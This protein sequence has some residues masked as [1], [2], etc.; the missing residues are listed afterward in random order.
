MSQFSSW[1]IFP[2]LWKDLLS[3]LNAQRYQRPLFKW[4]TYWVEKRLESFSDLTPWASTIS[5]TQEL[6]KHACSQAT[7]QVYC[8]RNSWSWPLQAVFNEFSKRCSWEVKTD[9]CWLRLIAIHPMGL[10]TCMAFPEVM[11]CALRGYE[12]PLRGFT[13]LFFF[14]NLV[15]RNILRIKSLLNCDQVSVKMTPHLFGSSVYLFKTFR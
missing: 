3:H 2:K 12:K 15:V 4:I 11:T 6:V 13:A 9:N 10:G 8:V 5:V 1:K 14:L 7:S